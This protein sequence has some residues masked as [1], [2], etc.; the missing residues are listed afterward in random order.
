MYERTVGRDVLS[1]EPERAGGHDAKER[2][3]AQAH[4]ELRRDLLY[5]SRDKRDQ[6]GPK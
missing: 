3:D 5:L 2:Q 4:C 6:L 1:R